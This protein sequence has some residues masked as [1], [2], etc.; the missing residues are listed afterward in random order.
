M[1]LIHP[2]PSIAALG[3]RAMAEVARAAPLG[4]AARSLIETAQTYL[5]SNHD[6]LETAP[7]IAPE[8]LAASLTDPALRLQLVRGM[9]IVSLADGLPDPAR[10][11][12]IQRFAAALDVHE[13]AVATI[14]RL[15]EGQMLLFKLDFYRRSHLR[16][17][18]EDQLHF[19]GGLVGLA[20]GVLGLRG[21]VEDL[22]LAAR[23]HALGAL[24]E[25]TLGRTFFD[26]YRAHGFAFPGERFGFPEA[27]VYH[28][29]T[30]ILS[31]YG[32]TPAEETLVT[33]F[34]AGYRKE[35]PFYMVL[36]GIITFSS[37]LNMA[38]V[39]QPVSTSVLAEPGMAE[40]FLKAVERGGAMN[41]DLS[42]N[43]DFWPLVALPLEEA[44][45]RLGVPPET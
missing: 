23:Y 22:E 6:D 21:M 20:K 44:R 3:F 26:H 19:H 9:V 15:A 5:L 7:V 13:D 31:G 18:L 1:S 39:P 34:T 35:N 43:W 16:S 12:V 14:G 33:A 25:G 40:R 4:P 41:T 30:H 45:A 38:P 17:I 27:G 11:A 8:V 10:I 24:P 2:D 42:A 36:F 29:F 32:T 37:G 28:D